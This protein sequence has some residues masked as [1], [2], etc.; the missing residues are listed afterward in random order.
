VHERVDPGRDYDENLMMRTIVATK[1][2]VKWILIG[3]MTLGLPALAAGCATEPTTQTRTFADAA[4]QLYETARTNL[5][6]GDYLEA[7]R[8]FNSLRNKFPYS[9]YAPLAELRIADAYFAQDSFATA[10][11]QYRNFVQ[12]HPSH[13]E[14]PYAHWR[15]AQ[16]F[17]QLMPEDWWLLPP[18]YERNLSKTEDAVR[19]LKHFIA[20]YPNSEYTEAA[21]DRLAI[22]RRRLADHELYVAKFY[23]ERDNPKASAMRLRYLLENYSGLGLDPQALFLLARSY[24]ELGEMARATTAL[25]DLIEYHPDTE[26]AQKAREYMSQYGLN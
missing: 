9:R 18:A 19:E 13:P 15:V 21:R 8:Q 26:L 14:V 11:Q 6:E 2:G 23:L 25:K 7:I 4:Q 24:I 22:A 12:L 10:V 1:V 16:A 20:R 17:Y 5:E 3:L